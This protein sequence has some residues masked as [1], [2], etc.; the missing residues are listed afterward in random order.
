MSISSL[1]SYG[2]TVAQWVLFEAATTG[3]QA[4]SAMAFT[5]HDSNYEVYH[6]F[7]DAPTMQPANQAIPELA[8]PPRAVVCIQQPVTLA[9]GAGARTTS[10]RP[11]CSDRRNVLVSPST[12]LVPICRIPVTVRYVSQHKESILLPA[13]LSNQEIRWASCSGRGRSFGK[14]RAAIG[15][16]QAQLQRAEV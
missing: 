10:K 2:L 9:L 8:V 14:A 12:E 15:Q 13:N 4:M 11:A 16:L 6:L 3:V 7:S 5:Y 1:S